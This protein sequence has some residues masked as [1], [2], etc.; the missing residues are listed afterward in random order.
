MYLRSFFKMGAMLGAVLLLATLAGAAAEPQQPSIPAAELVQ[1]V[2]D[3]E[4]N[5]TA[6][7]NHF[8]YEE[9]HQDPQGVRTRE[10][11]ET[12]DGP[13]GR[14][15]A[16]DDRP[17][18]EQQ[19]AEDNAK[20]E[21]LLTD[22]NAI[23]KK[24][25][26]REQDADHVKKMFREIPKA[27]LFQYAGS[28]TG[29]NGDELI[30]I[31]FQPNPAYS[32]PNRELMV[33][34]SMKGSLWVDTA[35]NRL[36]RMDGTLFR[37]V[38]FGWG[39]L[40]HLDKGGHFKVEQSDLG[41]GRWETTSMNIQFTGKALLFKTINMREIDTLTNFKPVPDNLTLAQG[42]ERLRKGPNFMAD[43]SLSNGGGNQPK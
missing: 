10:M 19:R 17:P 33:Y 6:E 20:L 28:E 7:G 2:I 21:N 31:D 26:E 24:K 11:I 9:R 39:L 14:L 38:N 15:I 37:D 3:H 32:P 22:P 40:G 8:M 18:N 34:K 4:L 27:F 36:A 13:V 43:N 12:Q 25:K 42:I 5:S 23:A 41:N 16:V 1:R 29:K 35:K 30:K